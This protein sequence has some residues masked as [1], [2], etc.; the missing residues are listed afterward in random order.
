MMNGLPRVGDGLLTPDHGAAGGGPV[1]QP[2]QLLAQLADR[3]GQPRVL[4]E[5]VS[6]ILLGASLLGALQP[7][8]SAWMFN[9]AAVRT[10]L[11]QLM[12]M[13]LVVLNVGLSL[14]GDPF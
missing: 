13:V 5:K 2:G 1:H 9:P 14:G 10:Q 12:F 8:F 3:L 6:E 4:G 7:Q 11:N